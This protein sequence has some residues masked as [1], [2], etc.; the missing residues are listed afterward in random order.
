MGEFPHFPGRLILLA[1]EMARGDPG[2]RPGS[3]RELG[4]AK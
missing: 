1:P 2:L 3:G 4:S